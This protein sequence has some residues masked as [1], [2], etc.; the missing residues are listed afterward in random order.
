M[1]CAVTVP[2]SPPVVT[3]TAIRSPAVI[4]PRLP[5]IVIGPDPLKSSPAVIVPT[6]PPTLIAPSVSSAALR[7]VRFPPTVMSPRRSAL[8]P[9]P[10]LSM[11]PALPPTVR[12]PVEWA[13]E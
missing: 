9:L 8:L 13:A 5:P 3:S 11:V 10:V 12:S 2:M 4:E 6:F 7:V 1:V